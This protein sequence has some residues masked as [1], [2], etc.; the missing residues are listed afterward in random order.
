M[1]THDEAIESMSDVGKWQNAKCETCGGPVRWRWTNLRAVADTGDE[2]VAGKEVE[3][4]STEAVATLTRRVEELEADLTVAR[5]CKPDEYTLIVASERAA[6]ER[7]SIAERRVK[8]LEAIV[9]NL[10]KTADGVPIVPGMFLYELKDGKAVAME[11]MP[12]CGFDIAANGRVHL[13]FQVRKDM[14]RD[15]IGIYST[16]AA[17]LAAKGG[18]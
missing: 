16:E 9:A 17:A 10:P 13:F 3:H 2:R 5:A 14:E 1:R 15:L 7:A 6:S 18:A 4:T 8:E 11:S 12:C